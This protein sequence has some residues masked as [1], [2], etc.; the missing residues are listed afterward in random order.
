[1]K[2]IAT[3]VKVSREVSVGPETAWSLLSSTAVWSLSRGQFAFDAGTAGS[4]HIR[5]LLSARRDGVAHGVLTTCHQ[6]PGVQEAIW[7]EGKQRWEVTFSAGPHRRGAAVTATVRFATDRG[8]ATYLKKT[9]ER[10]VGVWLA[11]ACEVLEGRQPWPDG[12]PADVQRACAARPALDATQSVSASV[13]IA[14][15]PSVV[16]DAVW[17]PGSPVDDPALVACGHVP[18][19]PVQEAG[20]MQFFV[21]RGTDSRLSLATVFVRDVVYQRSARIQQVRAPHIET[22]F[23]LVPETDVTRL[24][25]TYRWAEAAM[26]GEPGLVRNHVA[27]SV[28]SDAEAYKCAIERITPTR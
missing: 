5:C 21:S 1:M 6:Q 8:T 13:L 2:E 3:A 28:Q 14:A 22:D 23:L 26:A 20:E 9:W 24:E 4:E 18:G 10:N 12:M 17:A 19:T 16:W 7:T 15:P 11:R 27:D 25:L